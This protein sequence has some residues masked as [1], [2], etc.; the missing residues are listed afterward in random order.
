V[1][2]SPPTAYRLAPSALIDAEIKPTHF[3]RIIALAQ[4]GRFCGEVRVT[5]DGVEDGQDNSLLWDMRAHATLKIDG[6]CFSLPI[7]YP[8]RNDAQLPE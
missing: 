3:S 5:V 7:V 8:T 2:Y 1:K 6:I 4:T